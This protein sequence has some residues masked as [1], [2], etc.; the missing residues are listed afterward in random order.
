MGRSNL[1]FNDEVKLLKNT[2]GH[3]TG[4]GKLIGN[5]NLENTDNDNR[6]INEETNVKEK[7]EGGSNIPVIRNPMLSST[8]ELNLIVSIRADRR[9]NFDVRQA[10]F[11]TFVVFD[12]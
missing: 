11:I 1:L 12:L 9:I 4:N 10:L 2:S 6:N 5:Y 7:D 3:Y 8:C